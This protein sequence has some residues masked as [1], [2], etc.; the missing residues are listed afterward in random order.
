MSEPAVKLV[1]GVGLV[2]NQE[3]TNGPI[4]ISCI[5]KGGSA[6]QQGKV[7]VGDEIDSVENINV[8]GKSIAELKQLMRGEIGSYVN[9]KLRRGKQDGSSMHYDVSLMRGQAEAFLSRE[10]QRLQS[11]LDKDRQQ[12]NH[13]QVENEALN[14]ALQRLQFQSSNDQEEIERLSGD[15][16]QGRTRVAE[17]QDMVAMLNTE[18][19]ELLRS[20]GDGNEGVRD[21]LQKLTS[22]LTEAEARLVAAKKSLEDD[23]KA[24]WELEDKWKREKSAREACQHRITQM[25]VELPARMEQERIYRQNQEQ[26]KLKLQ[27]SRDKFKAEWE[28]AKKKLEDEHKL[29][30]DAQEAE[31]TCE[32]SLAAASHKNQEIQVQVK[33]TEKMLRATEGLRL[34][35]MGRHEALSADLNRL[36]SQ[37]QVREQLISDLQARIEE[38]FERWQ[39]AVNTAVENRKSDDDRFQD[40]DKNLI[41][42]L[43]TLKTEKKDIADDIRQV[44][45]VMEDRRADLTQQRQ[46]YEQSLLG[47]RTISGQLRDEVAKLT[48]RQQV[49]ESE[50]QRCRNEMQ[51]SD[52]ARR[53]Q[54]QELSLS[55]Q[56]RGHIE[57]EYEMYLRKEQLR[58]DFV[59]ESQTMHG[60]AMDELQKAIAQVDATRNQTQQEKE[61]VETE[62]QRCNEAIKKFQEL[63]KLRRQRADEFRDKRY[64]MLEKFTE[65]LIQQDGMRKLV[66][67]VR[68][69]VSKAVSF[70]NRSHATTAPAKSFNAFEYSDKNLDKAGVSSSL[71]AKQQQMQ[72]MQ[73]HHQ[74]QQ[75]FYYGSQPGMGQAIGLG[76]S[77][78]SGMMPMHQRMSLGA[79]IGS[80][81]GGMGGMGGMGNQNYHPNVGAEALYRSGGGGAGVSG[82]PSSDMYRSGGAD[83][84]H[85]FTDRESLA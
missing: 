58:I 60:N 40:R 74:Q 45:L 80:S 35:V 3:D 83:L 53:A 73:Q 78:H 11:L 24:T 10:M 82:F 28:K 47:Q 2:F 69:P 1:S 36:K 33:D 6:E 62:I 38:D 85:S 46:G 50:I 75:Q 84:R 27:Q 23:Q 49:C 31:S 18:K 63:D 43:N 48:Q 5:S 21:E 9:M 25:E 22:L 42:Q 13:A 64:D 16:S 44:V 15:L 52:G 34:E 26:L 12:L 7:Q 54:E 8:A 29:V 79:S 20:A 32:N 4:S 66:E 17:L 70:Y 65:L 67:D 76:S 57:A 39:T 56:R 19:Q 59:S 72:H 30:T 41:L 61:A 68:Q 51:R 71:P 37:Y 77:F 55:D 81:M 14:G